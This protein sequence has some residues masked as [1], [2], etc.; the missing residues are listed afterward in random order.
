M[1]ERYKSWGGPMTEVRTGTSG[2]GVNPTG[3]TLS[4]TCGTGTLTGELWGVDLPGFHKRKARGHLLPHTYFRKWE[5]QCSDTGITKYRATFKSSCGDCSPSYTHTHL[6][7]VPL[8]N[9]TPSLALFENK[10]NDLNLSLDYLVQKAAA[11]AYA[12]GYDGLTFLAELGKTRQLVRKGMSRLIEILSNPGNVIRALREN[13]KSWRRLT[14]ISAQEWLEFRYGWRILWYDMQEISKAMSSLDEEWSRVTRT[15]G[16]TTSIQDVIE[17]DLTHSI[18]SGTVG[19]DFLR[20]STLNWSLGSRGVVTA[21]IRPPKLQTNFVVTAWELTTFSFVVDW[22]INVGQWLEALS[23][24]AITTKYSAS[25]GIGLKLQASATSTHTGISGSR[26]SC[27]TGVTGF[28][29]SAT[30]EGIYLLRTPSPV[31]FLP[32]VELRLDAFKIADLVA[33][34]LSVF[35]K[36]RVNLSSRQ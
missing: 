27:C 21:D 36:F 25:S 9:I 28:S 13:G 22:F 15:A 14:K 32:Q 7:D 17:Q 5:G 35:L 2:C 29:G 4:R 6:N 24:A 3:G 34:L 31:P 18:R 16:L 33:I 23:F 19:I 12:S 10:L 1:A 20:V 8:T 26:A 11:D 30:S